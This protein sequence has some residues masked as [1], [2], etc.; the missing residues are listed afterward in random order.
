MRAWNRLG[1]EG[2]E[3][4]AHFSPALLLAPLWGWGPP[5]GLSPLSGRLWQTTTLPLLP[6]HSKTVDGLFVPIPNSWENNYDRPSLHKVHLACSVSQSHSQR[7]QSHVE[8]EWL[9]GAGPVLGY[10]RIG[11]GSLWGWTRGVLSKNKSK[12]EQKKMLESFTTDETRMQSKTRMLNL[13]STL[14]G[15]VIKGHR[16]RLN[17]Q[18]G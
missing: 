14:Y 7:E 4:P 1:P 10:Q 17:S 15:S 12:W 3:D 2:S 9:L 18:S 13:K 8:S 16:G 11:V 5:D 6:T